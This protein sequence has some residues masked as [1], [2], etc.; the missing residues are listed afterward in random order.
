MTGSNA[1]SLRAALSSHAAGRGRRYAPELKVRI[2]EH[3][4]GR[5]DAGASW[6]QISAELEV[7]CETLRRWCIEAAA[8]TTRAMVPVRVVA[9]AAERTVDVASRSGFRIEGLTLGEAVAA[10][11]ALG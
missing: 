3:A 4:H 7:S 5:R 9:D 11:R 2:I 8:T 1:S 10:L 6:A